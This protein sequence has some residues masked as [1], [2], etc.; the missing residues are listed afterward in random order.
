MKTIE[1][2]ANT[3]LYIHL[4]LALFFACSYQTHVRFR[5]VQF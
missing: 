3:Q 4:V 2:V 1:L 5:K